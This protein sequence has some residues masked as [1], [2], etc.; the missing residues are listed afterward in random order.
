[1]CSLVV[2]KTT[3]LCY[4]LTFFFSMLEKKICQSK[5][6]NIY[7]NQQIFLTDFA[8]IK[9]N[10]DQ[11]LGRKFMYKNKYLTF[12]LVLAGVAK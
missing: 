1:M 8:L 4:F 2:S 12:F 7:S 10:F 5:Y 3:E 9:R 11:N 6:L